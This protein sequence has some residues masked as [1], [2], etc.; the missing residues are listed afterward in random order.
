MSKGLPIQET[1]TLEIKAPMQL[2]HTFL[3]LSYRA[4][5]FRIQNS[6]ISIVHGNQ[7]NN[8]PDILDKLRPARQ[9]FHDVGAKKGCIEGTRTEVL[10]N[11]MTWAEGSSPESPAGYWMCGMAGTGKSTIAKSLCMM[12][13][14]KGL[15]GGAFF[16]S[17]QIEECKNYCNVIPTI[18]YQLALYSNNSPT[19]IQAIEKVLKQNPDIASKDP[20]IQIKQLLI[21]SWKNPPAPNP[22]VV[23]IDVLDECEGISQMLGYL[24]PAIKEKRMPGLK[25]FL[26]S[27]PEHHISKHFNMQR[28]EEE[29]LFIQDFCLHDVERSIVKKDIATFLGHELKDMGIQKDKLDVLVG[30]SGVLFIY[31]ATVVKYV[32]GGGKRAK[33]RLDN[34]LN[35]KRAAD[36]LQTKILD[37]LYDQILAEAVMI[38]KTPDEQKQGLQVIHTIVTTGKPVSCQIISELLG[39]KSEDVE[40]TISELQSVLYINKDDGAIYTFHASFADY[41]TTNSR[42]KEMHLEIVDQHGALANHCLNL[43]ESQLRF[44]ICNLPSSFLRDD[45]VPDIEMKIKQNLGESL[46]YSCVFW[47]YHLSGGKLNGGMVKKIEEFVRRKILFWIEA[48]NILGRMSD[49]IRLL[50][51]LASV[52]KDWETTE[53]NQIYMTIKE[54]RD[55]TM[56]YSF[57]AVNKMTPHLY[58]SIIPL[59]PS[60]ASRLDRIVK[61]ESNIRMNKNVDWKTPSYVH[62]ISISPDGTKIVSGSKDRKVRIW[63]A[64]TG[65]AIGQPLQGHEGE[66]WSVAFS[67]D[68]AK[69]V[70]GSEDKTVRIWDANTGAAIGQPLQGH[71]DEVNEVAF[72]PDGAKIVSGS[73]DKTVR[74]WDANT[75]AAIDQPLH[76]HEDWVW[77]VAFSPDGA[78]IV[79]GSEDKTVRI[80]DANT[81]IAIGQPL[82][83]HEDTVL[84]VAF[85]PDGAKIVSS[86][87]DQ[88]VRIWDANTGAAFLQPLQGHAKPVNSVAFSPDG[89]K[90]VSGSDDKTVRIWNANTGAAFGQSLQGHEDKV[91]SVAFSPD[92]AKIVSGS[93]DKTVRIWD[94]DT[95]AAIVQPLQG[96]EARVGSVAFSPDGAK[97]VSG[98]EDKTVRIWDANTGIAIGQPLQGHED[99]VLSV[100][101]SPDGAKIVSSSDDKTVRIWDAN[102]G[103]AIVQPLQGHANPVNSVAFSPDGAKIVSGSDDK[104][105]RIWDANT[106][107]AICQPLQ[108]HKGWVWSVAFSPDGAK[109]VSGSSDKT[110]RIWDANTGIAIGQPLQGHEDE[111]NAV[112]FSPDGAKIVSSSDDK[113]VRIWDATTRA[114]I[115]QPLH[116]HEARVWSVAFSPDGAKIVSGSEDKTVRIWDANT[117][118]AICQPLLGHE[119]TVLSV[120]FSPDGGKIVSGSSDKA[121]R[122]WYANT[123]A[124]ILQ[125]LQ[126]HANPVNSVAFSPDGAKIVSGSSDKTVRIWDANNGTAIGPP[127]QG[128]ES[129]VSSVAF[130]PD[131]AKIVSGSHDKT[132]RIWDVNTG[133]A[134]GQPLQGHEDWANSVA[135]SPDGAK[136]VS[137]S[138]DK[139]V[140]IWDANTGAAIG[141]PLQGHE[142]KVWS[143][144]FSPDGAK[145]VSGSEDKT[146]RIW[147]ANTG[148]A[149]GQPLQGHEHGVCGVWSVAF[150]PD[151]AKIVSGLSDNTVRIWDANTG[152]AIGQPLQGHEDVVLSVAFSPD[153]AKVVSGSFDKTVRIWDANTGTAIGQS[154]QGHKRYVQSV[155]FSPDGAKIVSGSGDN[156]VRI[157]DMKRIPLLISSSS[158]ATASLN[159]AAHNWFLDQHGW[160]RFPGLEHGIFWIR[161]EYRLTLLS[162]HYPVI[163]SMQGTTAI[164]FD[165]CHFIPNTKDPKKAL[166]SLLSSPLCPDLPESELKAILLGKPVNLDVVFTSLYSNMYTEDRTEDLADG[167]QIRFGNQVPSK[168]ITDSNEWGVVWHKVGTAYARIFP[169]LEADV[170][171]YGEYIHR[172]FASVKKP[173]YSRVIHFDKAVR[174]RVANSRSIRFIDFSLF[175][176]LRESHISD[177]G[178]CVEEAPQKSNRTTPTKSRVPCNNWN[179]GFCTAS[180]STCTRLHICNVCDLPGHKG[181]KCPLLPNK[182]TPPSST[183]PSKPPPSNVPAHQ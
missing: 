100:A 55:M 75:G 48:M 25:F 12:L 65:A 183:L 90:I 110:V 92:G 148:A 17:R 1:K 99:T 180:A 163:I 88:T 19:F 98:S 64:N 82:Q 20:Q 70:S 78:K 121:M 181:P 182:S 105:V 40:A 68:G 122:N 143:V 165:N 104:T 46:Q 113:T 39:Y 157:W 172:Q 130:S 56:I 10:H 50:N 74:I 43:M 26:T 119:D 7:C 114:A 109:I 84:S 76:G 15:L 81:G 52:L 32:T 171:A 151:G 150:S 117:G 28:L 79:S 29:L 21:D 154:L 47:V 22:M 153:G 59:F 37:D 35:L 61:V 36:K 116:G 139:T 5:H 94:V 155:A 86:S 31:A 178:S 83:G 71:E 140:R 34:V 62:S 93:E 118:A 33:S 144:A 57:S 8:T 160:V 164:S 44:N 72:S 107:A 45:E 162:P 131:G 111:V 137:G 89:A 77:S 174:S 173:F 112:A 126:G 11:I 147:D 13:E 60:I 168:Q 41:L 129:S 141:Q 176:D 124:A 18:A 2:S 123:G 30:K 115:G 134:I 69:I 97:I 156:T 161:P 67:P 4:H 136:I 170:K 106:G 146:V 51:Q 102:T 158:E 96:D 133:A 63:D 175:S 103:A 24:V 167:I 38:E 166:R 149:I 127:L 58:L 135:F 49:C 16:C 120:A 14:E 9:A 132:V 108:G 66:V 138:S 101:F 3:K 54:I 53:M 27:R 95:G 6:D 169:H 42:A 87:D 125:P 80:W 91:L 145:I 177:T 159:I 142:Y 73:D 152:A 128:H 179:M 85:S 23:V